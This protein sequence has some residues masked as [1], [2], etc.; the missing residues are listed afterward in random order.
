MQGAGLKVSNTRRGVAE[1][2]MRRMQRGEDVWCSIG[3][4]DT[5]PNHDPNPSPASNLTDPNSN[6]NPA[7]PGP[8]STDFRISP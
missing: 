3:L 5:D 1:C 6:P 8:N 7:D 4:A 2:S